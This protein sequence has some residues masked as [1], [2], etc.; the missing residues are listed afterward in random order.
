MKDPFFGRKRELQILKR[1]FTKR[2][3][4]LVVIKGRR[5]IGKSRLAE[6]FGRSLNNFTF[7]GLP[8]QKNLTPQHQRE[9]FARQMQEQLNI[10]AIRADDWGDLFWHLANYTKEGRVLIIMDEIN[11]MGDKDPTFLGKL[12]TAWDTHFKK[13]SEL[14]LILSGSMS[15]WIDK[16]ILSSTGFVGRISVDMTLEEL[17][18]PI[19]NQF[20]HPRENM[21]SSYEKFK[22][23][24]V[25]GGVPRYL[26]EIRPEWSAEENIQVL[27]FEK[28]AFLFNEFKRIFSDLFSNRSDSYLKIIQRLAQGNA[29]LDDIAEALEMKKGGTI[30]EYLEDLILTGYVSRDYT[31]DLKTGKPSSL[32]HY[33]LKD[34]YLRF[35]LKV[36]EPNSHKIL[37]DEPIKLAAWD[38]I[39]GLQFENLVL[40]NRKHLKEHLSIS[41]ENVIFDNPFFQKNTSSHKG[42]QI[43]YMV[44][45]KYH[46]L[47]LCE[48][49]FSKDKIGLDVITEFQEKIRRL[50]TPKNFSIWPVL[51]HVNGTTEAVQK[52]GFFSKIINF[53]DFLSNSD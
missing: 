13:N 23:L 45:T 12:K 22:V 48:I 21:V 42:C 14:I 5:R 29:V 44:Q 9:E 53:G 3:A 24:S 6:E 20:W 4:S 2:T 26:E 8:P 31:W 15:G 32:S 10:P 1:L 38:T 41:P 37:Q 25:T 33:R 40:N 11:W 35:Y 49:K 16:N 39:M 46:S 51:I 7:V 30:S 50:S 27:C 34:N 52:S 17:P 47:F 19:C 18:L 43:D 28:E 36:I